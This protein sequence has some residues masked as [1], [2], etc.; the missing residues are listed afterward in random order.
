MN[1]TRSM[2]LKL[3]FPKMAAFL[4]TGLSVVPLTALA[5]T[6]NP[7]LT[8]T[9]APAAT[10]ESDMASEPVDLK[11]Y[12]R[13][14]DE[15]FNHSH[16]MGYLGVLA[17]DIGPRLT[18][19]PNMAK[20]NKWTRDKLEAM[21]CA[22]AH[23]ESWGEF[24]MGWQQLNTWARMVAPDTAVF[25]AQATP[26]SPPTNGPVSGDVVWVN[27]QGENDFAKYKG[28]LSG[29]IVLLGPMRD[30]PPVDT[31]LVTR[32][33]QGDLDA[34]A[35]Y[36]ESAPAEATRA[37]AQAAANRR[38]II[39]SIASFLAG[40]HVAGVIVPSRDAPGGG[41]SGGTVF[42]DNS[43]AL[44]TRP[45]DSEHRVNIP[46]IVVAIENFGRMYRLLQGHVPV[47][48]QMD[49][50]TKI[51][52]EHEQG[53]NTIAEIPGTDSRLKDQIVMVGGHLDSWIAG[54][55]ATDNGAG[56]MVAMEAMRILTALNVHPRRTIRLALWSGEEE[57]LAGSRGYVAQ[58]FGSYPISTAP[59][60]MKLPGWLRKPAG[61]LTLKPEQA[62]VSAYFN[63]DN[64]GGRIRGIYLQRN[65]GLLPIFSQ[66][67]APLKYLGVTTIALRNTLSTDHVA[68]DRVGIPG[69]QFIQDP[70]DYHTRTHHSNMDSY[71]ELRPDDLMQAAV[72]ETIFVYNAAMRDEMLPRKPLPDPMEDLT[73]HPNDGVAY[74]DAAP[75]SQ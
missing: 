36:P 62:R 14:M 35:Q 4:A 11:M 41:G 71:E 16:V 6:G 74:P 67:I 3:A 45:Y 72:V 64:G 46:V 21:G 50:E 49:V 2:F 10:Q 68:F 20:A 29:K 59:D 31:P 1:E 33:S 25:I 37:A 40:E 75:S 38:N 42:D 39:D 66:W 53:Y 55:G 24:G 69:L 61:P 47:T 32:F 7:A 18:G 5:Q 8:E 65:A 17:D 63:L 28:K 13:I 60:Q 22:N 57:G 48:V 54:T 44:G 58:H 30:V 34:L 19:S 51:T 73:A 15:G 56:S 12:Q 23:L 52:G 26:W 70:L 27:I 43:A 9:I